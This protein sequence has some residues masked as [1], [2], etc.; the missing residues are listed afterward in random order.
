MAEVEDE[1]AT[2]R[3]WEAVVI[4]I[5]LET[6]H[7]RV[8]ERPAILKVIEELFGGGVVEAGLFQASS[9]GRHRGLEVKRHFRGK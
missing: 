5:S 1:G 6:G 2:E 3:V 8:V 4:L 9:G 7:E